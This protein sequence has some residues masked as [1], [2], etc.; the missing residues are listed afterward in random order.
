[1]PWWLADRG[2]NLD[3]GSVRV[4]LPS[5]LTRRL[6]NAMRASQ[7][8][9]RKKAKANR[10]LAYVSST[11]SMARHNLVNMVAI[12]AVSGAVLLALLRSLARAHTELGIQTLAGIARNSTSDAARVQAVGMLLDRGWVLPH[13]G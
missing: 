2:T 9:K 1:M 7:K 12:T 10:A 5:G 6:G 8:S 4:R 13:N 3:R 11:L